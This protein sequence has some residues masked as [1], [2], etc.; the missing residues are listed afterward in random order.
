MKLEKKVILGKAQTAG[1]SCPESEC[2]VD[3]KMSVSDADIVVGAYIS[4][5]MITNQYGNLEPKR[6]VENIFSGGVSSVEIFR[7]AFTAKQVFGLYERDKNYYQKDPAID[8]AS[9]GSESPALSDSECLYLAKERGLFVYSKPI[10]VV[11]QFPFNVV[12]PLNSSILWMETLPLGG[13]PY[14]SIRSVDDLFKPGAASSALI[15]FY[16]P[17]YTYGVYEYFDGL[18]GSLTGKIIIAQ[19]LLVEEI[20]KNWNSATQ[21]YTIEPIKITRHSAGPDCAIDNSCYEPFAVSIDAR[22]EVTWKNTDGF[23][24]SVTSG[25]PEDGPDG[26]F[27]SGLIPPMR[28]FSHTFSAAGAE[29]Y[30][31]WRG[32]G[33][34]EYY[35]TFHP[36]MKGM[37]VVGEI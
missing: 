27:D 16:E 11:C 18:S 12:I 31:S 7:D 14:H 6:T 30:S 33:I 1:T 13:G 2:F 20:G 9:I 3:A 35:C 4:K 21:S 19:P 24:H 23:S 29:D 10:T 37:V 25:T 8:F 26:V 5:M 36:W 28:T 15:D 17:N 32:E 34:Y 22:E